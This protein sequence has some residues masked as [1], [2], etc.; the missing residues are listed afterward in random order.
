MA[1]AEQL[2]ASVRRQPSAADMALIERFA[3]ALWMERGLSRNTLASYQSDLR[4]CAT[5]LAGE[6]VTGLLGAR[7][8]QLLGYL[9]AS[10]D[11]GIRPRTSARRLSTL[12]QFYQ[13]AV[14][15]QLCQRAPGRLDDVDDWLAGGPARHLIAIDS[16]AYPERLRALPDAPLALLVAGD[17]DVLSL[18]QLGVVGS[19]S[20]TAGGLHRQ[21]GSRGYQR[22]YGRGPGLS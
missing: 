17:L 22:H 4:H 1:Q 10:V 13:W 2:D 7:R 5:W 20:P 6:A 14:R 8:D 19:R 9:A 3:D 12:R 11:R 16:P 18:P 21:R 15:E